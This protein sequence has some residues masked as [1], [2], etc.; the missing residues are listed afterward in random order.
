MPLTLYAKV[1]ENRSK[2]T[3]TWSAISMLYL[4]SLIFLIQSMFILC[5]AE[6]RTQ[7]FEMETGIKIVAEP[8]R[9]EISGVASRLTCAGMCSSSNTCCSSSYE[10][11][12]CYLDSIC[13]PVTEICN[14]AVTIRKIINCQ[15]ENVNGFCN[16][17][18][19]RQTSQST[20]Y[21][22]QPQT[23]GHSCNGVDGLEFTDFFTGSCVHTMT[24][25][26]PWWQVDLGAVYT[27]EFINISARNDFPEYFHYDKFSNIQITVDGLSCANYAGPPALSEINE[28]ITITCA[29]STTGRHLKIERQVSGNLQFCE[30]RVFASL[31]T[32]PNP[33]EAWTC[34]DIPSI[35]E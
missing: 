20:T 14:N 31:T 29:A 33:V 32:C 18:Y 21:I 22:D 4:A 11:T 28:P 17:A 27:V 9:A 3:D 2:H 8:T 25:S 13:N 12:T 15:Q 35:C 24:E 6:F 34:R 7:T 19:R 26:S 5:V 1:T 16:V 30:I 23:S 10:N